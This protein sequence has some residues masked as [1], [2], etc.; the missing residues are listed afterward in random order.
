MELI[1]FFHMVAFPL[2]YWSI[3]ILLFDGNGEAITV[4]FFL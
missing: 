2:L 3:E 1:K 4:L